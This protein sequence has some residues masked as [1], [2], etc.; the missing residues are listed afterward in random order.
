MVDRYIKENIVIYAVATEVPRREFNL[1]EFYK[2]VKKKIHISAIE[3][4]VEN[5][6]VSFL[7]INRE[8]K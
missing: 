6:T 4:D 5:H 3:F 2:I 1:I 8:E 7:G